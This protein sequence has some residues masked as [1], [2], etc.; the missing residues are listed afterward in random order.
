[1]PSSPPTAAQALVSVQSWPEYPAAHVH[2]AAPL[3]SLHVACVGQ[4]IVMQFTAQ[5]PSPSLSW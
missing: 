2:T 4:P 5:L 3:A 1:L